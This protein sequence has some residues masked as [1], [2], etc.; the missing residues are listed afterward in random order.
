[1]TTDIAPTRKCPFCAEEIRAEAVV[2]KHCHASLKNP[3]AEKAGKIIGD[4]M[5]SSFLGQGCNGGCTS[6]I[7][8]LSIIITFWLFSLLGHLFK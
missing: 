7:G 2:C 4:A 1:M 8:C 5:N 6:P 3:R